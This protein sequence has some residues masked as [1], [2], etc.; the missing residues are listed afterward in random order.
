MNT[1][2]TCHILSS[3]FRWIFNINQTG[4]QMPLPVVSHVL[5]RFQN[6]IYPRQPAEETP[7]T[8]TIDAGP[9][10][11]QMAET[12]QEPTLDN[13][14]LDLS[15]SGRMNPNASSSSLPEDPSTYILSSPHSSSP[16]QDIVSTRQIQGTNIRRRQS[17]NS[18]ICTPDFK[19]QVVLRKRIL[20]IQSLNLPE[21]ENARLAQ[22]APHI[23]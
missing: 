1:N 8:A 14:S 13:R 18:L 20:E 4:K 6:S 2:T 10:S 5:R 9:G 23:C 3:F 21:R 16:L 19:A 17:S 22:V 15:F 7:E 11:T 12:D